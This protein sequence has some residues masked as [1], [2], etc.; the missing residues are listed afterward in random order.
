MKK[1]FTLI[2]VTL[3]CKA[4][5]GQ[6][7]IVQGLG[8]DSTLIRVGQT[9]SGGLKGL[10]INRPF[11]DTTQANTFR[12]KAYEGA[13]IFCSSDTSIWI[14]GTGATKWIKQFGNTS[15]AGGDTLVWK[16]SGNTVGSRVATP[17]LGTLDGNDLNIITDGTLR[18]SVPSGGIVF[19]NAA[20]TRY[21]TFDTITKQM[22]Y[23]TG[24]SGG[25][26]WS[27]TGNAGTT[28]G[29]NFIGTTDSV[30]FVVK[31]HNTER[32]RTLATGFVGIG[33]TTPTTL[34]D[35]NG[36]VKVGTLQVTDSPTSGYV[37]TSDASGNAT[38]QPATV[39]LTT[40]S[41]GLTAVGSDVR[42][43]GTLT[44]NT[45]IA[46]AGYNLDLLNNR[47]LYI[48]VDDTFYVAD[49]NTSAD[50]IFMTPWISSYY[51]PYASSR[52]DMYRDTIDISPTVTMGK[53][54]ITNLYASAN[55]DDSMLVRDVSS[56]IVGYRAIPAGGGLTVGTTTI[57]S[58]TNTR[59]LYNN[60]GVLGEYLVTGSG[61]TAV[62]STS[63]TFT[64][65]ITSP[66]V[67]GGSAVGSTL[68]LQSTS[69]NGTDATEGIVF[70]DGSVKFGAILN[71]GQWG[72][73]TGTTASS[74]Y[75]LTVRQPNDGAADIALRL[76][77]NNGTTQ[78][79]L[80]YNK[81]STPGGMEINGLG[82]INFTTTG[83]VTGG[84]MNSSGRFFFGGATSATGRVHIAAGTATA[85]TA[86]L[87]LTSGT[88]LTAAEAGAIEYDGT[89][90]YETNSTTVRGNVIVVRLNSSS[91][92]TLTL[93]TTYTHYVFTG[94]TTT[95]T[96]PAVSGT[97][98]HVFYIKN[99]GSGAITL[100]AAAAAN[101]IYSTAAV[102][103][104]TINAGESIMLLSDGTYF[105][106]E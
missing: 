92:G 83:S 34:L 74:S 87:K 106:V 64:T 79:T 13:M 56:G 47:K 102:N 45:T 69:A 6:W 38:W 65:A 55:A 1:I 62:L 33:T 37:L 27:L 52:I 18:L 101:E 71:S 35:V 57:T 12:I 78:M 97:T 17:S 85:S 103:T 22:Y 29:T 7:P 54:M 67:Y 68:T 40:A 25:S 16:L 100:N 14:R 48:E 2:L 26:G 73:G 10:L 23:N 5:F 105:L 15:G 94:T 51:G 41:N 63:P 21:L 96:L 3:F 93:A 84:N 46:G 36:K 88:N 19:N 66:I 43:G 89:E 81:I 86:P 42:L 104:L 44:G 77:A 30:P 11:T 49:N 72:I 61:T 98:S 20:T 75:G 50:R 90:L 53:L 99:R 39:G 91:A 58:G 8:S 28:A 31:T 82:G 80:G 95:W 32:M 4:G 24:G 59:I 70:Q 9:Y 60:S 76:L